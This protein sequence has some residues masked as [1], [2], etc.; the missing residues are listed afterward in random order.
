LQSSFSLRQPARAGN[1]ARTEIAAAA[2]SAL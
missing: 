2:W 1:V